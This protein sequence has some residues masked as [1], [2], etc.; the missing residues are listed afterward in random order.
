[1][2][3]LRKKSWRENEPTEPKK[4]LKLEVNLAEAGVRFTFL[5]ITVLILSPRALRAGKGKKS[6][7]VGERKYLKEV[8]FDVTYLGEEFVPDCKY[9]QKIYISRNRSSVMSSKNR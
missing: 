5:N 3:I 2:R 7:P 4:N 1:M 6:P 9:L 8:N